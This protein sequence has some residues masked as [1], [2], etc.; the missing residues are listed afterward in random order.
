MDVRVG[1]EGRLSASELMLLNCAN[2]CQRTV[3]LEKTS[4]SLLDCKKTKLFNPKG[5]QSWIFIGRTDAEA[6]TP[7]LWP[8]MQR[9][10][11]LKQKDRDAGQDWRQ[12]EKGQQ[13]MKWLDGITDLMDMSLSKL[14][15]L[16]MDREAWCAVVHRVAKNWTWATELNWDAILRQNTLENQ[17]SVTLWECYCHRV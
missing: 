14:W 10:D 1:P 4:E 6:E 9:A 12:Q 13:R 11:S 2:G 15:E 3:V 5:N 16:V 17:L 8:P 7:I